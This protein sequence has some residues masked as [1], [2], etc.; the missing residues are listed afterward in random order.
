[1][2]A[3]P[4]A[5]SAEHITKR[6]GSFVALDDVSLAVRRGECLALVGASGSGKTTLLRCFNEMVVPDD[7]RI[8]IEGT[9][10]SELDTI[11]LR[12]RMG[13]VPQD[14]GL[15]PHWRVRRNVALVPALQH[16]SDRSELADRALDLVGL[17][18]DAFGDRWPHELSGGER[19]RVAIARALAA[20]PEFVLLDEPFGALDA[21]TRADVQ[22]TFRGLRTRLRFT[23]L[24]VTHDLHEAI[25]LADRIAVLHHG[26]IEQVAP[27]EALVRTPATEYV[28]RLLAQAR[29]AADSRLS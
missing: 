11:A 29:V 9:P 15:L 24:F 4:D 27:P 13:Y 20:S 6:Y 10:A 14:G 26:R 1:V 17:A 21:I 28:Q 3:L 12:R 25:A 18:P 19:Q 16:A 8:M 23:T 22:E 2:T 5:L 7:G